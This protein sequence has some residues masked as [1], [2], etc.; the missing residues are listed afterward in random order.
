[1]KL[2]TL[3][4]ILIVPI[5]LAAVAFIVLRQPQFGERPNGA[6]LER[7]HNSPHYVDGAFENVEPITQSIDFFEAMRQFVLSPNRNT[8]PPGDIPTVKTNLMA[9]DPDEH[10]FVW[11]GHSSYFMQVNGNTFLVDPVFSNYA[12][13]FSFVNRAFKGTGTYT[14]DDIPSVDYLIITHDHYDHLDYETVSKLRQKVDT[15]ICPL[16]VG[17]HLEKWGFDANTIIEVDWNET[18]PLANGSTLHSVTARHFSGRSLKRN[19]ALWSSFVLRTPDFNLF[20]GCDGGYGSHFA[21]IGRA[22]GPFDLAF[23]ENGQYNR[24]WPQMHAFPEENAQIAQDLGALS[25][26]PIHTGKFSIS[27]HDWDEPLRMISRLGDSLNL[28]IITP[29][30]GEVVR[31][32]DTSQTFTRWWE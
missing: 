4:V 12:A 31:L 9:L 26:M 16:G 5:M 8:R 15:V 32:G 29:K 1:M 27:S 20:L 10:V 11:F 30:I 28:N 25:V 17:A 13:P 21:E 2:F 14:V 23:L 6:R 24:L 19:Q 18:V 7:V 22:Y 3:T